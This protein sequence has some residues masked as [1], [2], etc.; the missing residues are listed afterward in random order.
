MMILNEILLLKIF[1]QNSSFFK[2][3]FQ[4]KLI[5]F[6][7]SKINKNLEDDKKISL[8]LAFWSLEKNLWVKNKILVFDQR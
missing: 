6:K 8:F 3:N 7:G 1:I 4:F 5:V 2:E